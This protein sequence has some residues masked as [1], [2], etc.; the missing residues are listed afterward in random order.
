MINRC[1]L[2][3]WASTKYPEL[4]KVYE[5]VFSEKQLQDLN[6]KGY[7]IY[8]LPNYPAEYNGGTVEGSHIDKF[9]YI[10][11]DMDLKEGIYKNKEE[12][13]VALGSFSLEPT[14]VIDSGNG[15]HVYWAMIDLDAMSFLRLQ[16]RLCRFLKT[17]EAV[18]KIYQLMRLPNTANV[19]EEDNP[20]LCEV[21]FETNNKY[22]C[23]QLDKALP[24]IT[25][26]DEQYCTQHY[27]KTYKIAQPVKVDDK[28][29][30]KFSF[31]VKNNKE[32]K[33]IWSGN[34]EDRSVS[35]YRLGHIMFANNFTKDEAL[36]VLINA[37]K[38]LSRAPIH[39]ISYA[40]GIVDKIWTYELES[41]STDLN[42]S[43]SVLQV[44]NKA[45]STLKGTRFPCY[46]WI[47]DTE[48]GFRLGQV[49]GLVAG[50][51]VGKTACA[52]NLFRGF[53]QNNPDYDHF[54]IPLEQ[55][56]NEIADRWKTMCGSQTHL[57]EKVQLMSNY[58]DEGK[59]RHL[60]FAEIKEYILKYQ[61]VTGRKVGAVVI[62]HIG[63]LKKK[64]KEGENQDL[65]DICHSM[66]GFAVETNTMLIMQSQAPREKAGIGDLELNKDAAY[67]TVYFESYCDYLITLW[68]P[69]KRCYAEE[70]CP[71]VTAFKFCKIRHKRKGKDRIKEDVRYLMLFDPE[72]EHLRELSELEEKSFEYFNNNAINL[73]KQDRKTDL[74]TYESVRVNEL[75]KASSN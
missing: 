2:S 68:Q 52:L 37:P 16:R 63:A 65:M 35:D 41:E 20:K 61:K 27:E 72:T 31:L 24:Q 7:N 11:V 39:R 32:V 17:D 70:G 23:E 26:A 64:G 44:L 46:R 73:R 38:A 13:L 30:T 33:E 62:D 22:T 4:K 42:L 10:F 6:I 54:F 67:G 18:S 40:Q 49:I 60:S 53:V 15:V 69:L 28:I 21:L 43:Q 59:F 56:I 34:T 50:S 45:G 55:P 8:F 75:S 5:G 71:S 51:G 19:K 14:K 57:Y 12:F 3:S 66:K 58:D 29:P 36:S 9:E 74:L 1:I 48:H 25:H 47:D